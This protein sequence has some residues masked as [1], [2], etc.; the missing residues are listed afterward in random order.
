MRMFV[1]DAFTDR[2]F[3]GNPAGVC[4]LP[5]PAQAAWMQSVAAEMRHS[6]TAFLHPCGDGAADYDLRWFTP[7]A[8]VDLCGHATL[9]AAHVLYELG[10]TGAIRFATRSGVLTAARDADGRILLDFP[11]EPAEPVAAPPGLAEALGAAPVW[12]GRNRFD[13]L[14]ELPDEQVVRGL[15]PDLAALGRLPVRGVIVTAAGREGGYD[16]VSRCFYPAVG[17]PEDPVTGSAHCALAPYWAARP[18][19]RDGTLTGF[20]A[21]PRGGL[22]RVRIRGDRVELGGHAVTVLEGTLRAG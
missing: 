13:L 14:C 17:V 19:G 12:V 6:E 10:A 2:P 18:A 7:V 21:S 4:L 5:G 22:V 1:V 9:A 16:F 3:A 20:Q 15:R 11:A 8:E